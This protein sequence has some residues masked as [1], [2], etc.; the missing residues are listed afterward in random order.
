VASSPPRALSYATVQVCGCH[1]SGRVKDIA[2]KVIDA[3]TLAECSTP[4]S[5]AGWAA[6]VA[7]ASVVPASPG[8]GQDDSRRKRR[9]KRRRASAESGAASE[10]NLRR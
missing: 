5:V 3:F 7:A 8:T 6:S 10:E 4:C 9:R 2:G 1:T